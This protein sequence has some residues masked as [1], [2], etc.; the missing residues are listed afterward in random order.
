MPNEP[1]P[2]Q[3]V[4]PG[5]R[6]ESPVRL[7]RGQGRVTVWSGGILLA[8]SHRAVLVREGRHPVRYYLPPED[9]RTDLLAPSREGSSCPYKGT[10]VHLLLRGDDESEAIAWSYPTTVPG[11]EPLAGLIAFYQ[12]RTMLRAEES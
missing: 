11:M 6:G 10:A 12:E 9:V 7:E 8:D 5:R 3:D 2:P 4:A 1:L